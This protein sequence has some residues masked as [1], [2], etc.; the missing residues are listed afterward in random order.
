MITGFS[1]FQRSQYLY[2]TFTTSQMGFILIS[3][4]SVD[5]H[6]VP[7]VGGGGFPTTNEAKESIV[8]SAMPHITF[9]SYLLDV[10]RVANIL[11]S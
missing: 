9:L 5:G 4:G 3:G 1:L 8:T 11:L 6:H 2:S 10:F 7:G